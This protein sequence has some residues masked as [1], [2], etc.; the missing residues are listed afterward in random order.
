MRGHF[1]CLA[2]S[3]ALASTSSNSGSILAALQ[4]RNDAY[5]RSSRGQIWQFSYHVEQYQ[6]VPV[7]SRNFVV[8]GNQRSEQDSLLSALALYFET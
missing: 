2:G 1:L 3:C 7:N 6:G 5:A 4:Q 8:D